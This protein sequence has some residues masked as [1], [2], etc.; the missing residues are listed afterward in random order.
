MPA[1]RDTRDRG[2]PSPGRVERLM[3]APL[4]LWVTLLALMLFLAGLIAFGA[5]VRRAAAQGAAAGPIG[6]AA[7]AIADM[8]TTLRHGFTPINP[9]LVTAPLPRLPDG[10]AIAAG[11]PRDDGYA[12]I[13]RYEPRARRSVVLLI[14]LADG[15]VLRRYAPDIAAINA[16]SSLRSALVDLPRDHGPDRYLMRH[17]YLMEDGGLIFGDIMSPLVRIDACG[18]ILWTADGLYHHALERD[19]DG[20]FLTAAMPARSSRPFVSPTFRDDEI[21]RLS[22]GGRVLWRRSVADLLRANGLASLWELRPYL[23]DPFHLNDVEPVLADGLAWRRGD[24][25]LSFR[26]LSLVALYRPST[27]KVLWWRS[28]PWNKQHDVNILDDHRISIFDNRALPGA[29]GPT[30][31]GD[32]VDGHNRLLVYDFATGAITSPFERGFARERI[33]TVTEG[34]GTPLAG[35]DLF[36]EE[37]NFGRIE[38]MGVDGRLRWRYIA[39]D[40]RGR[41]YLLGWS[42]YLD[43]KQFQASVEAATRARCT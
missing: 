43:R 7:L 25:F 35:G 15:A 14:R 37:S 12:L 29:A 40:D 33:R 19:R 4:P 16:R 41:R 36:V 21:V 30:L 34:R 22:P 10:L 11:Q 24:L 9:A 23:D 39:G 13:A 17:P 32:H 27:D 18:R 28:G 38:R 42:R 6:R 26:H 31:Y 1:S 5:L 3:F 2:R 8:P 20:S